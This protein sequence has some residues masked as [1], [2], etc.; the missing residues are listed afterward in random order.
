MEFT[1]AGQD[2]AEAL[3]SSG[4]CRLDWDMMQSLHT[5]GTVLPMGKSGRPVQR[6]ESKIKDRPK[7]WRQLWKA[8]DR[9]GPKEAAVVEK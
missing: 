9:A 4:P 6:L 7:V 8:S 2:H 5:Q 1:W 3:N